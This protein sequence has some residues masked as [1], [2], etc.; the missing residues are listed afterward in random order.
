MAVLGE[1]RDPAAVEPGALVHVRLLRLARRIQHHFMLPR[2]QSESFEERV[3]RHR[4]SLRFTRA[5]EGAPPSRRVEL[6]RLSDETVI[7]FEGG[8][9]VT[10]QTL[11]GLGLHRRAGVAVF[12]AVCSL[13][14]YEDMAPWNLLVRPCARAISR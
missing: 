9:G 10:I 4:Y 12:G 7:G 11:S 2:K 3:I 6:V 13:P 14:L 5:A 1:A 8:Q